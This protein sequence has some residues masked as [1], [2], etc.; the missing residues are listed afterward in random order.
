M[1]LTLAQ[2]SPKLRKT[3]CLEFSKYFDNI[4]ENS[5]LVVFP[6]LALNGYLLKDAVFED[7]Y[8]LSE[9]EEFAKFSISYDLVFGAVL[10]EEA[11]F[12][13]SAFYCSGGKI[14]K[15]HRK[16]AL[17]NYGLFQEARFFFKGDSVESFDTKF[18]KTFVV[19]CEELYS[20]SIMEK[21]ANAKPDIVI[22]ISNSPARGFED[23]GLLIQKQ[24]ESLLC[25]TALL[26][27]SHVVF[28]NRIGF[29]DG[30]GF[31]GGSCAVNPKAQIIKKAKLFKEEKLEITIN[32]KLS[33]TQKY[34]LRQY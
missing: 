11:K 2:I 8:S 26:S 33:D 24:W 7:A 18:G 6:E 3:T 30:L 16:T 4:D 34:L 29:E 22:V 20:A 31:W 5:N 9:I 32:K 13:N 23:D 28:A 15:I 14:I 21:I 12:Y 27:G 10:K 19:I 1:K 17:P 25:S